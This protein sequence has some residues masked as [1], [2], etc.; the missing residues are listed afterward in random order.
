MHF[1]VQ[2][3]F[4]FIVLQKSSYCNAEDYYVKMFRT[5]G[6]H[7]GNNVQ[8]FNISNSSTTAWFITDTDGVKLKLSYPRLHKD[9]FGVYTKKKAWGI[10][11][12]LIS[13]DPPIYIINKSR[14]WNN[15]TIGT[16]SSSVLCFNSDPCHSLPHELPDV[17]KGRL[18]IKHTNGTIWWTTTDPQNLPYSVN[19]ETVDLTLYWQE[20]LVYIALALNLIFIIIIC[21]CV[22][23]IFFNTRNTGK[24]TEPDQIP[25]HNSINS[26][27]WNSQTHTDAP[28]LLLEMTMR[29][30][31]QIL[32]PPEV[33]ITHSSPLI[34]RHT[35][36]DT[37]SVI[38]QDNQQTML[39]S[40]N[41]ELVL[42]PQHNGRNH[43]KKPRI[44]TPIV[45]MQR[46]D[47]VRPQN[48]IDS[49]YNNRNFPQSHEI[50][51]TLERSHSTH[52]IPQRG[53]SV[54]T[55]STPHMPWEQN[56]TFNQ[57][58]SNVPIHTNYPYH[59]MSPETRRFQLN[60]LHQQQSAPADIRQRMLG[61]RSGQWI[62]PGISQSMNLPTSTLES[63]DPSYSRLNFLPCHEFNPPLSRSH[64]TQQVSQDGALVSN[65][66]TSHMP[67]KQHCTMNTNISGIPS[68]PNDSNHSLS[69][70][71]RSRLWSAPGD[72]QQSMLGTRD[73]L[74]GEEM[75]PNT[76]LPPPSYRPSTPPASQCEKEMDFPS[77]KVSEHLYEELPGNLNA[78][79]KPQSA[80]ADLRRAIFDVRSIQK[81]DPGRPQ[82][83]NY[84][85]VSSSHISDPQ[86]NY[87]NDLQCHDINSPLGKSQST[88]HISQRETSV[89]RDTS[90]YIPWKQHLTLNPSLYNN[91]IHPSDPN[92]SVSPESQ[93]VEL[94][95]LHQQ[96][97]AP[98][99]LQQSIITVSPVCKIQEEVHPNTIQTHPSDLPP[100]PPPSQD[101]EDKEV[102]IPNI[103]MSEHLY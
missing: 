11:M 56:F 77:R 81:V 35:T 45:K 2:H 70:A 97:S 32:N 26:L 29:G 76:I 85:Y 50:N 53:P 89:T 34:L 25:S 69:P 13:L 12:D 44:N 103:K 78:L 47:P 30:N 42:K 63:Y 66:P 100:T 101:G 55:T 68:H 64:S 21:I 60:A 90:S 1:I 61:S 15:L 37:K 19:F 6:A 20:P 8:H 73:V 38:T 54:V 95:D 41:T 22:K 102:D 65:E 24:N 87:Q 4:Y 46:I 88:Q 9:N 39:N 27:Y 51:S 52:L 14:V 93:N 83:L 28:A 86:Y 74:P 23:Y 72:Q 10:N 80:T 96:Q 7:V 98:D 91:P 92:S 5:E 16:L 82:S 3:L 58:H 48:N 43:T 40:P 75:Y 62:D 57:N 33:T 59:P 36:A 49:P 17:N 94:S 79:H 84:S 67:W 99:D 31:Q 71:P 18:H